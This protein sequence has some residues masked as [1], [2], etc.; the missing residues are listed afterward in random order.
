MAFN[1]TTMKELKNLNAKLDLI[2][3]NK[4]GIN[5]NTT[6]LN[7]TSTHI[8]GAHPKED[9]TNDFINGWARK[10]IELFDERNTSPLATDPI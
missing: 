2:R 10:F 4:D 9:A 1:V 7:A 5:A 8:V 6:N 3:K